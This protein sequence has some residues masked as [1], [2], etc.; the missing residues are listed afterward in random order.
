MRVLPVHDLGNEEFKLLYDFLPREFY[1]YCMICS[2]DEDQRESIYYIEITDTLDIVAC[3][4]CVENI[5]RLLNRVQAVQK[6]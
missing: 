6:S 5:K 1:A 3:D 4:Q 2:A